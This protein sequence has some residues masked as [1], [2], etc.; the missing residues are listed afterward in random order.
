MS[1]FTSVT[2]SLVTGTIGQLGAEPVRVRSYVLEDAAVIPP[3]RAVIYDAT[4]N[5]CELPAAGGLF[6]GVAFDD[7]TLPIETTG[8]EAA[9]NPNVPVLKEGCVWVPTTQAVL[10]TDAVYYQHDATGAGAAGTFRVDNNGGKATVVPTG[11]ARW[12]GVYAS[13]KALLDLNLT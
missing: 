7:G 5:S 8:Y 10:P 13:G 6:L 3:G 11:F 2:S 9:V 12:A 4:N 1:G